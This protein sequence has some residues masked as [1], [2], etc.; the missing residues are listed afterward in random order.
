[1]YKYILGIFVLVFMSACSQQPPH[2]SQKVFDQEDLYIMYALD[3][4]QHKHYKAASKVYESLYDKAGKKEYLYRS[5]EN[6]IV[7]KEYGLVVKKID[8]LSDD[9][10]E[11]FNLARLKVI[12]LV[13][14]GELNKAKNL[15]VKLSRTTHEAKDYILAADVYIKSKEYDL[16]LKYLDSAYMQNYDEKVLDKISIILYVNLHKTKDAIARL[17]TH[18]RMHGCS[19]LICNRLIGFYS[20]EN[21]VDGLLSIYKRM[22]ALKKSDSIAKKIIQIYSYKRDY[23]K[24][25]DFLQEYHLD[26]E[27]LLQLY[28]AAKN[29]KMAYKLAFKL[30]KESGDYSYLGQSAIYKYESYRNISPKALQNVVANL[31]LVTKKTNETLYMNYLGYILIDHNINVKEG[32]K[33]IRQVLKIQPNSAYYLDSLAWGYYKLGQCKKAH[34][35]IRKVVKLEGGDDPEVLMHLKKINKCMK[36]KRK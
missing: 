32:M 27:L 4:E 26:N 17:E 6:A 23:V 21:N 9:E 29:Y 7:A 36:G 30:Y 1:M 28:V 33:Y 19:Q 18:T 14:L 15:A 10:L 11:D 35:I 16:A 24:L 12:A 5:L 20:N 25:T 2:P 34:Q 13:E 3:A 31:K 22:Y 8:A